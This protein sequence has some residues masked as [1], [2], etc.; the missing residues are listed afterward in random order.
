MLAI[1]SK[2]VRIFSIFIDIFDFESYL[3]LCFTYGVDIA[4]QIPAIVKSIGVFSTQVETIKGEMIYIPNQLILRNGIVNYRRTKKVGIWFNMQ[5][6]IET[7][8]TVLDELRSRC[9][10][11]IAE[12]KSVSFH[13]V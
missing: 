9:E 11:F 13:F 3:S 8:S 4:Y 2:S 10:L 5:I 7:P 12:N 6:S 1:E